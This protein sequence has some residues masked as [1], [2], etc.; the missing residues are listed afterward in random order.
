[1]GP[2]T[3]PHP[4]SCKYSCGMIVV[5]ACVASLFVIIGPLDLEAAAKA[6]YREGGW[7]APSVPVIFRRTMII[8]KRAAGC[9]LSGN[10]IPSTQHVLS[11]L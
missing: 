1:M 10:S 7:D 6:H 8:Y 9:S 4:L 3:T 11:Q 2:A 5:E